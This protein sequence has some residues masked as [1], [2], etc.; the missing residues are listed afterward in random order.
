MKTKKRRGAVSVNPVT[1]ELKQ[2]SK[3]TNDGSV[4]EGCLKIPG[5]YL[6]AASEA[7]LGSS[8][9]I[10][11]SPFLHQSSLEEVSFV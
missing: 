1:G 8:N 5:K 10:H 6:H 7:G 2:V 9:G 3:E 11:S 4:T